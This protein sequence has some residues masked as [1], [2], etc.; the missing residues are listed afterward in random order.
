[1]I[2]DDKRFFILPADMFTC[3]RRKTTDAI[4]NINN[5]SVLF[6]CDSMNK[7]QDPD[8]AAA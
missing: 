2:Y 4:N 7:S 8:T 6:K 3:H 5:G 1:M